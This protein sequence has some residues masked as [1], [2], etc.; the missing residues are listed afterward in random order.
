MDHYCLYCLLYTLTKKKLCI[1]EERI[2][3][4]VDAGSGRRLPPWTRGAYTI[5][6]HI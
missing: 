3:N 2:Y 1:R 5:H 6:K 4:L